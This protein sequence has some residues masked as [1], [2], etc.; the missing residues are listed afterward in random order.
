MLFHF[1]F[2]IVVSMGEFFVTCHGG[3]SCFVGIGEIVEGLFDLVLGEN[4]MEAAF[5]H[6]AIY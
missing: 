2:E 5:S 1:L 6:F 3:K 4:I